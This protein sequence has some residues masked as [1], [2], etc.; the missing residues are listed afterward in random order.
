MDDLSIRIRSIC[1]YLILL[2]VLVACTD[3]TWRNDPAVEAARNAC[4]SPSDLDYN[5]YERE[6]VANSNPEICRLVGMWIDDMCLQA[7]YEAADDPSICDRIYLQGVVPNCRAYYAQRTPSAI[8]QT[9]APSDP[10]PTGIH[11]MPQGTPTQT[12]E[13][14][15]S[16]TPATTATPTTSPTPLFVFDL[17]QYDP[18]IFQPIDLSHN[19]PLIARSDETVRLMFSLVNTIYCMELQRYCRLESL[20]FFTYGDAEAF[21]TIPLTIE[22]VNGMEPLVARLPATD[23]EGRPLRYYAEFSVPEAGYT[24]RY[25]VAGTI[26]LFATANFLSIELSAEKAVEPGDKVYNFF[27]GYGPDKVRQAYY[28]GYPNLVGPPAMDVANDGRIALMDPVNERVLIYNPNEESYA[29]FPLPFT[30]NNNSDLAFDQ[31]G[32]L[33]ICD[34]AGAYVEDTPPIPYCYRLLPDGELE[35]MAPVYV[36]FPSKITKDLRVLD[37]FDYRLVAPFNSEG[38]PNSREA[39]RQKET[40]GIPYRYVEG[41]EGF[42]LYTARFADVKEDVAFEVHSP[43]G[44]SGLVDFEKTPQGYLMIFDG[45]E[46]IRAVWIDPAGVILKDVTLPRGQYSELSLYG[47]VAVAQD[48]SLYVLGSTK[49]G[50]EIHFEGAP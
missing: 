46:Q 28:E 44:F 20:P 41:V 36:K 1:F 45:F 35:V 18:D 12:P 9:E 8:I 17:S 27:W 34:F 26:D 42:D 6:A 24:L 22:N 40:W 47:Q 38:E 30:Y 5:C 19:P 49:R 43:A 21:Q 4:G 15:S 32:Q 33:M 31:N 11:P 29:S 10:T 50:I 16:A 37:Q 3:S 2:V 23:Q 14:I 25:P 48:G 39:Q 7:V 13:I